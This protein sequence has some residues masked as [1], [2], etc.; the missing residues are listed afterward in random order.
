MAAWRLVKAKSVFIWWDE[1]DRHDLPTMCMSCAKKKATFVQTR[2]ERE[3]HERGP[4]QVG[5][6]TKIVR[7][8][9]DGATQK[10]LIEEALTEATGSSG[11]SNAGPVA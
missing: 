7:K 6:A 11:A 2:F 9:L 8:E 4:V 5:R 3:H 10:R 1:F